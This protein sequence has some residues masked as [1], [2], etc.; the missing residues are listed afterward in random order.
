MA[1]DKDVGDV[2]GGAIF[3]AIKPIYEEGE[4]RRRGTARP[5]QSYYEPVPWTSMK[6]VVF[7]VMRQAI[8]NAGHGPSVRD[9]YYAVRPLAYAHY[10]WPPGKVLEYR[11]FANTLVVEYERMRGSIPGL[12]RDPRGHLHEA[13]P[14]YSLPLRD[15]YGELA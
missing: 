12:W 8:T 6:N 1:K 15:P 11:Y 14:R 7:R 10:D 2:I 9:L 13:H 5:R 4:R 3:K